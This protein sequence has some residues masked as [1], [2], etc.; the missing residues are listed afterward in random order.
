MCFCLRGCNRSIM[1]KNIE[2]KEGRIGMKKIAAVLLALFALTV[3]TSCCGKEDEHIDFSSLIPMSTRSVLV[4]YTS[5]GKTISYTAEKQ[6]VEELENWLSGLKCERRNFEHGST[7]ADCDGGECYTFTTDKAS[8]SYVINGKDECYLNIKDGW[9]FV[10]NPTNPP[11]F[12]GGETTALNEEQTV[13]ARAFIV[14]DRLY[15]STETE[16]TIEG[17]CGNMDGEII[18]SVPE[19]EMPSKNGESNFGTG[20][21]YQVTGVNTVDVFIG[22]KI[23]V[24]RCF[25]NE[26]ELWVSRADEKN[27]VKLSKDHE[28]RIKLLLAEAEWQP[29][30]ANCIFDCLIGGTE[31]GNVYYHSDCG[32]LSR[33]ETG[34]YS[35][36]SE[37]DKELLNGILEQYIILGF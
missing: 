11:E 25:D 34:E 14:R 3:L 27:A 22:D 33:E 29:G 9:Y 19:N 36:L 26:G 2:Q 20:Y 32:T 13:K 23:I 7:P 4:E 5:G 16:S 31:N 6:V 24:F 18:S 21:S 17:R 15:I 1:R 30:A 35:V 10:K 12:D 37:T 28:V 8:F